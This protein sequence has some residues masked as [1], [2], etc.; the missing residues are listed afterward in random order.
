MADSYNLS[1]LW[2]TFGPFKKSAII[3]FF[4]ILIAALSETLGLGMILPLLQTVL[5]PQSG[6]TGATRYLAPVLNLFPKKFNL[7]LV[8][9]MTIILILIKN[10]FTF[11]QIYYSNRFMTSFRRYWSSGIME[12]YIYSKFASL[13]IEKQGV[14]LNNI[15]QE[16]TYASKALRDLIDFFAKCIISFFILMLLLEVNWL[17]TL[18][19]CFISALIVFILRRITHNYAMNVGKKKIKLNQQIS[20]IAAES[21]AGVRQIKTFS[22]EKGIINEFINKLDSLLSLVLRFNVVNK[23]PEIL[24]EVVFTTIMI[25]VLLFYYYIQGV[26]VGSIIPIM[27]L[28]LICAQR[29]FS[30]F[31]SLLSERMSIISYLPS[32]RLVSG[33]TNNISARED[34]QKGKSIKYLEKGI[35]FEDISFSYK[36]DSPLFERMKMEFRKGMITAIAGP[37]GSGKSTICDM[38]IGLYRPLSGGIYIDGKNMTDLNIH[39]WRNLIGYI[40]QETFLFNAS[41]RDNILVGNPK[42]NE[43]EMIA[44]AK[45]AN[46]HE[47]IQT[48]PE[49][50]ETALGDRGLTL[51]GGQRQRIAIARALIRNPEVIILDEATSSLDSESER[52]IEESLKRFFGEKTIIIITHRLSSLSIADRIYVLDN[53]SIVESGSYDE[54]MKDR[55]LFWKLEQISRERKVERQAAN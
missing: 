25:G 13:V 55:G 28:F 1:F 45:L 50:Y 24:G 20:A 40:S 39:S 3:L 22:M 52:Q 42:A 48:L 19:V 11:L 30:N 34:I 35:V 38:L 14:L 36:E 10:L 4:I 8:C 47:F 16:P 9:G 27:A 6:Y 51:S 33:L 23:I 43:K 21:I 7:L 12:T 32:F 15:V 37:S 53:G 26:P 2:S 18:A 5:D 54:L 46:I 17:I 44:A 29:L 49:K 41:I 31:T